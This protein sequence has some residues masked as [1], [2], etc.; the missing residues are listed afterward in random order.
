MLKSVVGIVLAGLISAAAAG[1]ASAQDAPAKVTKP[2]AKASKPDLDEQVLIAELGM[3][4][5]R[6]L[7]VRTELVHDCPTCDGRGR[8]P[9]GKGTP[10]NTLDL[11]DCPTCLRA[12]KIVLHAQADKLFWAYRS[13]A[14]RNSEGARK[15]ADK[16][17]DEF[18]LKDA[19][20]LKEKHGHFAGGKLIDDTHAIAY[21][22]ESRAKEASKWVRAIEG[23]KTRWFRWMEC[24]D[25]PWPDEAAAKSDSTQAEV[26]VESETEAPADAALARVDDPEDRA[27]VQR[28]ALKDLLADIEA[29]TKATEFART[30]VVTLDPAAKSDDKQFLQA[31]KAD[32]IA[33]IQAI[34]PATTGDWDTIQMDFTALWQN[35]FGQRRSMPVWSVSMSTETAAKIEWEHLDEE[36]AWKLFTALKPSYEGWTL[37]AQ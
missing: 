32:S 34:A 3:C 16:E 8:V 7:A 2:A 25:D 24:A 33:Y 27:Q 31:V 18:T 22:T 11:I 13:P 35:E 20:Q 4:V 6:W 10:D 17:I 5:G 1:A 15:A 37:V 36:G 29:K 19:V 28:R 9:G 30:L 23:G 14:W 26:E 21:V 12:G